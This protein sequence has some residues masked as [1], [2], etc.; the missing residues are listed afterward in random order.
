[1]RNRL[2]VRFW[3]LDLAADGVVAIAASLLIVLTMLAAYRF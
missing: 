3:G 2:R 1:M